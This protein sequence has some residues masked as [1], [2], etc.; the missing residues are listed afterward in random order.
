[1]FGWVGQCSVRSFCEVYLNFGV[2]QVGPDNVR[3]EVY[4]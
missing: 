3:L 1:M 2:A 4:V